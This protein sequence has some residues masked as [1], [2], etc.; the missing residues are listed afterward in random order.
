MTDH[1]LIHRRAP[2][3]KYSFPLIKC[4]RRQEKKDIISLNTLHVVVRTSNG[5]EGR[6]HGGETYVPRGPRGGGYACGDL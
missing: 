4:N 3:E 6:E 5:I 2:K 1:F